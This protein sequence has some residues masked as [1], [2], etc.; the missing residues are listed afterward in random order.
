MLFLLSSSGDTCFRSLCRFV[1]R[2]S[3]VKFHLCPTIIP[4]V[5]L[6]FSNPDSP[7]VSGSRYPAEVTYVCSLGHSLTSRRTICDNRE[8]DGN[9]EFHELTGWRLLSIR[10]SVGVLRQHSSVWFD[11]EPRQ[12]SVTIHWLLIKPTGRC[13][14]VRM[15]ICPGVCTV[16]I[17]SINYFS[18]RVSGAQPQAQSGWITCFAPHLDNVFPAGQQNIWGIWYKM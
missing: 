12:G 7:A 4:H 1:M 6:G 18:Q 11:Y 9:V 3:T 5:S 14:C 10:T 13:G 16:L 2:M 8:S 15:A 17:V